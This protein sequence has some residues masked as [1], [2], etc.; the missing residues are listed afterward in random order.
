MKN[1]IKLVFF[2]AIIAAPAADA[3]FLSLRKEL[4]KIPVDCELKYSVRVTHPDQIV[5]ADDIGMAPNFDVSIIKIGEQCAI[6]CVKTDL[7]PPREM[8][9]A[10]YDGHTFYSFLALPKTLYV[11]TKEERFDPEIN[12][13]LKLSPAFVVQVKENLYG[14]ASVGE[15][16]LE[17]LFVF[18][19][20][21]GGRSLVKL[22]TPEN[23]FQLDGFEYRIPKDV[24]VTTSYKGIISPI[25][26]FK[27]HLDYFNVISSDAYPADTFKINPAEAIRVIDCDTNIETRN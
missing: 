5:T 10:C 19:D 20:T 22:S 21:P 17:K 18:P 27:T 3:G 25:H 1:L 7:N 13:F 11:G 9:R 14:K 2:A 26:S 4:L 23:D 15:T 12:G 24:T 16:P 6:S 8:T